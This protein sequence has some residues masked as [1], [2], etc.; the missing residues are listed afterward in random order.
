M[1]IGRSGF[2]QEVL[3]VPHGRQVCSCMMCAMADLVELQKKQADAARFATSL[4]EEKD[5]QRLQEMA[6][7]LQARCA[8][9]GRMARALEAAMTPSGAA[10]AEAR[11]VLTAEQRQRVAEQTGATVEVVTLRDS[12]DRAWSKLMPS[13]EPREIEAMAAKEAAASRLRAETRAQVEKIIRELEKLELP[14]L[15]GTIAQLRSDPTLGL[16]GSG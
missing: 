2:P 16:A 4:A 7:Q 3:A 14:E 15:A 1:P 5:P 13:V 10:R 12:A 8:E 11:V 6:E 9:L